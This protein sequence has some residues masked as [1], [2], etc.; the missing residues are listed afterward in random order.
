M[1]TTAPAFPWQAALWQSLLERLRSQRLSH[2]LLFHG[3]PGVG[4]TACARLFAQSSLCRDGNQVPCGHCKSCLLFQ[5]ESHPDYLVIEPEEVGKA[6]RIDQI[7]ALSL[8]LGQTAQ[9]GGRKCIVLA[10]ADV[11][12]LSAANALLKSLEEPPPDTLLLLVTSSP[13]RL[14][15]T[16]RSRCQ[17]VAFHTPDP[18][19][20]LAWLTS[21]GVVEPLAKTALKHA[22]GAPLAALSD[23]ETGHLQEQETLARQL[24]DLSS[25]KVA[26]IDVAKQWLN[27]EP[28]TIVDT[29]FQW[30][31]DVAKSRWLGQSELATSYGAPAP[32]QQSVDAAGLFHLQSKVFQVKS[33]LLSSANPNKQLLWEDLLLD[34]IKLVGGR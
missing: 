11:L 27:M 14:S 33:L 1:T 18:A 34:W 21:Q 25:G 6:I 20:S 3:P 32:L 23:L 13:S 9:Q 12:N 10:P 8:F 28:L 31:N 30:L 26:L 19:Q 7:R 2:A 22:Y 4:K 5:A 17:F 15:A 16:I 24:S 29:L